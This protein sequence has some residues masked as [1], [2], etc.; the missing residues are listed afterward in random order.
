MYHL[1]LLFPYIYRYRYRLIAGLVVAALGAAVS[2]F[3]P[4]VLRL[5]IDS[6]AN[7]AIDPHQLLWFGGALIGLAIIDG[8][9]KF[10][11]RMLIAVTSYRIEND[12]RADLFDR[13]L[14]FDQM[15]YKQHY[16]G[17]LM[18]RLTNDLSAVRQFLGPGLNGAATAVLTFLAATVLMMLVDP[19]LALIVVL[20]LPM[21]TIVFVAIGGR[22][23]QAFHRVQDQFGILSTRAQENF[24]GIRTVKAFAQEEAE[25][26]VFAAD[27]E[28]YRKLNLHYVLLSGALWPAM[29]FCLGFIAALILLVGGQ[30]VAAGTLTIGELVQFNAYLALLAF[31]MIILGWMVNLFQ[32]ATASL[33]R[34]NDILRLQPAIISP[35]TPRLPP[36]RGS[37]EF[38]KVGVRT[39]HSDQ[40]LLRNLSFQVPAGKVLAI[41]GAT[42]AGKTT[43]VNLLGRVR[44]PDEGQVLVDG[45]DVRELDLAALRR[46][47]GY[48]PQESFLFSMPL[49]EN[50]GFGVETIDPVRLERVIEVSRLSN[51][52]DQFPGGIETMVGERGVTLSG[53]QKQRVAIARALMR[54]P[55]ILILDDALSSVDT[56]TAAQILAGLRAEMNE[57]TTIIIAQRIATVRDAD[58]IIVLEDGQIVERGSHQ[59]LLARNGRYAAMYRRELLAA[60]LEREE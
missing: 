54:D 36:G 3:S 49:R 39:N 35:S 17:D 41:V 4:L 44:D 42:G 11:Q 12:L 40:W 34:L 57:R 31:P 33:E 27:N 51:D 50:I 38:R 58:Q 8:A 32:Q 13:L 24:A 60:E 7:R 19:V 1:R 14:S 26:A 37:I 45:I 6:L 59:E 48:V 21:A 55:R 30:R 9:M 2:S 53:G 52:L 16:T 56:H 25:I 23:R 46:M 29:T 5:A 15:F 18:A 28:R 47:I 20:L 10:V 22:M 43:L